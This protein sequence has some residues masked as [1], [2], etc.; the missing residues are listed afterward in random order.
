VT[1]SRIAS[2]KD[3]AEDFKHRTC[4]RPAADGIIFAHESEASLARLFDF[5]R[6]A[7]QYEP[8]SFAVA[9]DS[10][11]RAAELFTPDFY[12]PEFDLYIEMTVAKPELNTRKNRKMRLLAQ[13]HPKI[14]VKLLVRRDVERL[15][16]R[17]G[18][19]A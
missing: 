3:A 11:G 15:F 12:L 2:C 13:H 16:G 19:A 18:S 1:T 17:L 7:W 4:D 5:Y 14:R 9:W 8:R 6:I 10:T